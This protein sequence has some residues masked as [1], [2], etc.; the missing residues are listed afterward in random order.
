M[1]TEGQELA[2]LRELYDFCHNSLGYDLSADLTHIADLTDKLARFY[3]EHGWPGLPG[4]T[5]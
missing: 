2:L 4:E 1:T 3:D 5:L